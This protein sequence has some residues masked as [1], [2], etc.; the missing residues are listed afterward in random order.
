[1]TMIDDLT[2]D[3][4]DDL[5][6]IN[7]AEM[8]RTGCTTQVDM[9]LS[10]KQMQS[11]VRVATRF[12]MRGFPGG[13]VPGMKRLL[14]IWTRTDT[15]RKSVVSGKSV[16]VRVDLGGRRTIKKHNTITKTYTHN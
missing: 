15:A 16:S 7:L 12:G 3:E 2:E 4:L 10:L 13:M 14:P 11:Y 5:T 9:S 1:M 6:A 8:L